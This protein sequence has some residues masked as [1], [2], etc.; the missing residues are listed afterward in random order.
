MG[1]ATPCNSVCTL[2][3]QSGFCLGCGRTG[4]EIA[5]WLGFSAERR[6]QLM[7]E[8]PDRLAALTSRE[9]PAAKAAERAKNGGPSDA[10]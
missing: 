8:L 2:D 3:P 1:I 4:E 10:T 7:Q 9:A 6:L 5:C